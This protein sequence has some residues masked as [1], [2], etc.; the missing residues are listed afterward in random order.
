VRDEFQLQNYLARIGYH[1]PLAPDFKTLA[2][3]QAAQVKAIAFEALDPLLGRPVHINVASVQ[4]K[5]VDGRRGGYC[6]E[7]NL[8]FKTALEAIGF[9]VTGLTGRVRWRFAPDDPLGP[10]THMLLKIDLPEGPYIADAGFGSCLLDAPLKLEAGIEQPTAMGTFRLSDVDGLNWL[11]AKQPAGWRTMYVFDLQPQILSDY[12][13][14]SWYASTHPSMPFTSMAVME[15]LAN[16]RRYR[17]VNRR[18]VTEA[19]D[20]ELISERM[21]ETAAELAQV[22]DEIFG[23][24]L[25][26]PAEE[27]WARTNG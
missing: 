15:R 11:S 22:I 24:S 3:L 27:I 19:R 4:N 12:V 17:L 23:V 9:Q 13:L 10:R 6:F 1:G 14:G 21:I 7:Q 16:D 2:A 8:L 26:V 25:P 5:L 18:L 20:G